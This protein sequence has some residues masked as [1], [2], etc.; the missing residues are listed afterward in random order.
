MQT[1]LERIDRSLML[2]LDI[3]FSRISEKG[4]RLQ[5]MGFEGKQ[6]GDQ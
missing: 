2:S 5:T 4:K 1:L 3:T 6:G